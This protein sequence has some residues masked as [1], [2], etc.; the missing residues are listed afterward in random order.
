METMESAQPL[1]NV[2]VYASPGEF[3]GQIKNIQYISKGLEELRT[4]PAAIVY[5]GTP[6]CNIQC[7]LPCS[8]L[9]SCNCDCG[10]NF[11]Y[12]TLVFNNGESKYLYR[13]LG[14]LDCSVCPSGPMGRFAYVKSL[15]LA[16]F[17]QISS[18]LGT[19]SVEMIKENNCNFMGCCAEYFDVSIKPENKLVG[20]V[21]YKGCLTDC[22]SC[23]CKCFCIC[24]DCKCCT[25]PCDICFNYYYCCDILSLD[26]QVVYTIF[27]KRCCLSCCPLD[28]C[29]SITFVIKNPFG[30]EVGKIDL[31]RTCC[32]CCGLRGKN[33]TYTISFPIDATPEL[34]LTIIN[35]VIS[36]DMFMF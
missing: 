29:D 7:C 8:C 15:N 25:N 23:S 28:C 22:C 1:M 36:I 21:R 4:S 9:C 19:E 33:C 20:F 5:Y 35:A 24:C 17:D 11:I 2:Q 6:C 34:K 31:R 12:N 26:K 30:V 16:S 27:I 18:G 14:R 32:T 13:N 10:D 3:M